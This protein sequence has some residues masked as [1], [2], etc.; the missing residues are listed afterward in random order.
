M[1]VDKD[2]ER[3]WGSTAAQMEADAAALRAAF[4]IEFTDAMGQDFQQLA[5]LTSL[6]FL[7]MQADGVGYLE[8]LKTLDPEL[9][10]L[11]ELMERMGIEAEGTIAELMKMNEFATL[12]ADLIAQ[13]DGLNKMMIGLAS[14][15][16]LT[17]EAFTQMSSIVNQ[18]FKDLI[19]GGL[20][21]DAALRFMVPTLSALEGAAKLYGLEIDANTQSIIDEARETGLMAAQGEDAMVALTK[22][23]EKAADKMVEAFNT[24]ATDTVASLKR[25]FDEGSEDSMRL[26]QSIIDDTALAQQAL[27]TLSLPDFDAVSIEIEFDDERYE[28]AKIRP[29]QRGGML[30]RP[31][32]MMGGEGGQPEMIGPVGFMTSALEGAL[33]HSGQAAE[34]QAMLEEMRGL[35]SDMQT[36]PIMM[37]DAIILAG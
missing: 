20:E 37:R 13:V 15:G 11:N 24:F 22:A 28:G 21:S 10:L 12:N 17:E 6:T 4:K 35:R 30:T 7:A 29:M 8:I 19:A 16:L 3:N 1:D 18:Q 14:S 2:M 32:L 33:A 34:Q 31:T 26:A 9:T 27:D 25:V 23:I 5:D 36:L